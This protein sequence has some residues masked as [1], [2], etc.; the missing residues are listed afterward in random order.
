[1]SRHQVRLLLCT[2]ASVALLV[3]ALF[4]VEWFRIDFGPARISINL[5]SVSCVPDE[6]CR[7]VG[8]SRMTGFYPMIAT[9]AFWS[10]LPLVLLVLAQCGMKMFTGTASATIGKVGYGL[11]SI[12]FLCGFGAGYLFGPEADGMFEMMGGGV[13]RTFAPAL[14]L[15]GSLLAILSV[16]YALTEGFDDTG[17]EY[18]PVVVPKEVADGRLPVTP[19]NVRPVSTTGRIPTP[20]QRERI[21]TPSGSG[22]IARPGPRERVPTPGSFE[23]IPLP[24]REGNAAVTGPGPRE[25]VPTPGAFER[26]PLPGRE[27]NAAA[28][29]P[30]PRER[31]PT[32][33]AFERIPLPGRGD[34]R[35]STPPTRERLPDSI[36]LEGHRG[37]APRARTDSDRSK[38]RGHS[39]LDNVDES[40]RYTIDD[41]DQPS[42]GDIELE[43]HGIGDIELDIGDTGDRDPNRASDG[44][45]NRIGDSDRHRTGERAR[46]S[47]DQPLVARASSQS[48]RGG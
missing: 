16:R 18:K 29:G 36:P 44:E 5:Q 17:G 43:D 35:A 8:L 15:A 32:P 7:A 30:G 38:G 45:R 26:I 46:G 12:V 2:A 40:G 23:H 14:L 22:P 11:G 31:V 1:M 33:G 9:A 6:A 48:G 37:T 19:L 21:V 27:G 47:S 39:G 10:T 13:T 25:R 24:G 42:V 34:S 4:V 3:S 20:P 28:T 41:I